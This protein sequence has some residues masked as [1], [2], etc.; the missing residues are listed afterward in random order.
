MGGEACHQFI[1]YMYS[2]VARNFIKGMLDSGV[3]AGGGVPPP[4]RSTEGSH[5]YHSNTAKFQQ[6]SQLYSY[7]ASKVYI[8]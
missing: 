7:V 2:G 6:Y 1:G 5:Y 4:A 8:L 3:G